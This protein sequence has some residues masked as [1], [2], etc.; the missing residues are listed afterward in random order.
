MSRRYQIAAGVSVAILLLW[1]FFRQA[2]WALVISNLARADYRWVAVAT[3]LSLLVM[4]QRGWRWGYL[5]RPI[6]RIR[7]A[8]LVA[9]TFMGWA[10]TTLLPGRVGEVARPVLLGRREGIS[11]SAAFATVVLERLFD[12][13]SVLLILAIYLLAFPLPPVLD[14]EGAAVL[15]GMRASG[16]AAVAVVVF[17]VLVLVASQTWPR[18]T[19]AMI[20]FVLS[21]IPGGFGQRLVPVT[22]KFMQGFAGIKE[23]RLV[24]AIAVHSV[25]IWGNILLTYYLLFLAFD[26]AVPPYAVLPLVVIIVIGVMVPTPAAVGSFHAAARIGLATLWGVPNELAISYAIISHAIAFVPTTVIGLL[27]LGREGLSVGALGQIGETD[28]P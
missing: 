12:V 26:I 9:C 6:K 14:G 28:T 3:L 5:L 19:D 20:V 18:R 7:S 22:H 17:V 24:V 2:D 1:V 16:I 15:A 21:W 11:K 8:P 25:V 4:V 13:L 23:P 27:L 10:F